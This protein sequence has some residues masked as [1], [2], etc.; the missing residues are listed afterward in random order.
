MT[1]QRWKASNR[2][3]R[4][5]KEKPRKLPNSIWLPVAPPLPGRLST[6]DRSGNSHSQTNAL[7]ESGS[8][9]IIFGPKL[10]A[11]RQFHENG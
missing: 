6:P 10:P 3:A 8:L 9:S 5:I 1:M 4:P 2:L 11:S 7:E